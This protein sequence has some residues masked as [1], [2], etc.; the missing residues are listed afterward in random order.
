MLLAVGIV[1]T[2]YLAVEMDY[3]G[4]VVGAIQSGD[5]VR[6]KSAVLPELTVNNP[7]T[8]LTVPTCNTSCTNV[9]RYNGACLS[10]FVG[11]SRQTWSTTN[12]YSTPG[13]SFNLQTSVNIGAGSRLVYSANSEN[14][15]SVPMVNHNWND[16]RATAYVS[17]VLPSRV[18]DDFDNNDLNAEI[19]APFVLPVNSVGN[20]SLAAVG[21]A[22]IYKMLYSS[23]CV[24]GKQTVCGSSDVKEAARNTIKGRVRPSPGLTPESNDLQLDYPGIK[25]YDINTDEDGPVGTEVEYLFYVESA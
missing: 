13:R 8:Y 4:Q 1:L 21:S 25:S 6:I 9:C 19:F 17:N 10:L 7:D 2:I 22:P 23:G 14:A 12:S 18:T 15:G 16:N 5:T 3:G 20:V 24:D 11:D